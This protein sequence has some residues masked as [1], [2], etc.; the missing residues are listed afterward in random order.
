MDLTI[1]SAGAGSG[2]TYTLTQKLTDLLRPDGEGN[3][4]V[5]ASG[6]IA[7]TFTNKAA[8]ELKER[9]RTKLLQEGLTTQADAL[10][11]ALIGTVHSIGGQLLKRFAFEAGVSPEVEIMAEEDQQLWFNQSLASVLDLDWVAEIDEW[12]TQFGFD[13]SNTDWR[14][15]V[16]RIMDNART[17]AIRAEQLEDSKQKSVESFL[18]MLGGTMQKDWEGE[19]R[20]ELNTAIHALHQNED[21]TKKKESILKTL[22][23]TLH[24]L[25]L[26]GRLPWYQWAELSKLEPSV[27]T[28]TDLSALLEFTAKH[29]HHPALH[30]DCRRYIERLFDVAKAGLH[31][32]EEF[33]KQRGWIDYIDMEVKI[34]ELLDIPAIQEVLKE[35]IDLLLVDEFQDTNPIQLKI[36]LTLSKIAK[37][38]IWVG[39]PKQSIYGFRGAAPELMQAVLKLAKHQEV[40]PKSWRSRQDLVHSVNAIFVKA[41]HPLEE[42]YIALKCAHPKAEEP[43][44]LQDAVQFWHF[45]CGELKRLTQDWKATAMSL[46]IRKVLES[47]LLVQ[48]KGH[49]PRPIQAGDI[50][51]LCRTNGACQTIAQSLHKVGIKASIAQSALLQTTE[52]KLLLACLKYILNDYDSLS[53][54]EILRLAEN[55]P[56]EAIIADRLQHLQSAQKDENGYRRYDQAWAEQHPYIKQLR[57]LRRQVRELSAKE[58]LDLLIER[59]DLW[60]VV[61]TWGNEAQRWANI[62]ALRG[63]ALSYEEACNRLHSA[64]TL[65][66]FLLWLNQLAQDKRDEQGKGSSHDAVNVLTYHASKGLEWAFVVCYDLEND[67]KEPGFGVRIEQESSEVDLNEPLKG[68]YIRYW[69]NPYGKQEKNT[70]LWKTIQEHESQKRARLHALEEEKRLLY[71]G[72]TRARDYLVLPTFQHPGKTEWLNRV[73]HNGASDTPTLDNLSEVCPWVWKGAEIPVANRRLSH[74]AVLELPTVDMQP[75]LYWAARAGER[76][77]EPEAADTIS[78]LYPVAKT[79]QTSYHFADVPPLPE[80][81]SLQESIHL[82]GLANFCLGAV[83]AATTSDLE[84]RA[85]QFIQKYD[86]E[87]WLT[88]QQLVDYASLFQR[89]VRNTIQVKT[90]HRGLP[91]VCKVP[92]LYRG[93]VD[94]AVESAD[95]LWLIQVGNFY[96]ADLNKRKPRIKE[97]ALHLEA[98]KWAYKYVP[99]F[100]AFAKV[101]MSVF[102]PMEGELVEVE[103]SVTIDLL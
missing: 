34:V 27:K 81:L 14:E 89:L 71:V 21:S 10:G 6:I 5:R 70:H 72:L 29:I 92:K 25:D 13:R 9:V 16:K 18:K 102:L 77:H 15:E 53:I 33:K 2:K 56:L 41:L 103:N 52:S 99:R 55:M 51:V 73:Y 42:K 86:W 24:D 88:V 30:A 37:K 39:D 80:A 68:R 36:F 1:I 66:G 12:G 26:Y 67:L 22:I 83:W 82:D 60:R 46:E 48:P 90:I 98:A 78:D 40:L 4:L 74:A 28:K 35:E 87:P 32:Y 45:E 97:T 101:R 79:K 17:N 95:E 20:I 93:L 54:A 96:V 100:A 44:G 85:Q 3:S 94:W 58:V 76:F 7:T 84:Q 91:F 57:E 61:A 19:L 64:A 23:H 59:L 62:D 69:L 47:G 31:A 11:S 50:A 63:Y 8:A 49:P 38:A 65:G 43:E 75:V